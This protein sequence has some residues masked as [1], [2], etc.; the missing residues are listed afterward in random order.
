MNLLYSSAV[1]EPCNYRTVRRGICGANGHQQRENESGFWIWLLDQLSQL[2]ILSGW[3]V[4][5]G[6]EGVFGGRLAQAAGRLGG[7]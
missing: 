3:L 5:Q 7:V 6:S 2:S 4:I 1:V